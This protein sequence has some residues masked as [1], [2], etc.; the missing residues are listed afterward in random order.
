MTEDAAKRFWYLVYS[1]PCQE[2]VAYENLGR[3]GYELYLPMLQSRRRRSG[4]YVEVVE[5]MFPR[6]LFI[7]LDTE[8][9][10]W[11]PIR[12][13]LGVT[14]I[15]RFGQWPARVPDDLVS[16][17]RRHEDASGLQAIPAPHFRAGDRVRIIDGP[18][19]G[20]EAIFLASS[21]RERVTVLLEIAGR[22]A[23]VNLSAHQLDPAG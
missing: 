14:S 2:R 18:M 5:P 13:T 16:T 10:N 20:Y 21:S 7:H 8:S 23:K 3:Q 1:K 22:S 4:R 15:V 19:A 9:D 11:A 17:L 12:S 6:Y